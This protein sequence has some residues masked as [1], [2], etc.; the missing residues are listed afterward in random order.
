MEPSDLKLVRTPG[1]PPRPTARRDRTA[2]V[3]LGLLALSAALVGTLLGADRSREPSRPIDTAR[4]ALFRVLD[5]GPSDPG[6][7]ELLGAL[8]MQIG[9][10]PLDARTRALYSA[11][12]L[13]MATGPQDGPAPAF[14]ATRA[15][16]LA[17]VT[18]PVI[19]AAA[20]VLARSGEPEAAVGLV[21]EMFGYDANSA[22]GLLNALEP[23]LE[24]RQIEDAVPGD[25][26][27]WLAWAR[28]IRNQGRSDDA[29]DW[30]S[31]A[32]RRWPDHVGVRLKV[33]TRAA[34]RRD[35]PALARVLPLE[36]ELPDSAESALLFAFRARV[37]AEAGD[38]GGARDDVER[39]AALSRNAATV[40]LHCGDALL[41]AD[42]P[43]GA[44]RLWSRA[45]FGI[46]PRSGAAAERIR[47]LVRMA[48]LEDD[49]GKPAAALRAW[50]AVLEEDPEQAEARRRVAELGGPLVP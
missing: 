20:L 6:V 47:L 34:N 23:F 27:A 25:P 41:A 30:I 15:A 45:L 3:G 8:R 43:G 32:H 28:E 10:R 1:W 39:A 48:R 5:R 12:L 4:E 9:Q 37:R 29:D 13:E 35:W 18:V 11:L 17:P 2:A 46:S 42:D 24:P 14:H 7:R 16:D 49:H 26:E 31:R 21:R 33:A 50:K 36:E 38:T 40:L 44:R 22:A 19:R